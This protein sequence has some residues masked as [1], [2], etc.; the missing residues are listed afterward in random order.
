MAD[1]PPYHETPTV[2]MIKSRSKLKFGLN[3]TGGYDIL[4]QPQDREYGHPDILSEYTYELTGGP[5]H[6]TWIN[7]Q[8][9]FNQL[10]KIEDF[11]F[12]DDYMF[13]FLCMYHKTYQEYMGLR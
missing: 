2:E 13:N 12:S 10:N 4:Y 6:D 1:A 11:P 9:N 7:M 8:M 5:Y 3:R